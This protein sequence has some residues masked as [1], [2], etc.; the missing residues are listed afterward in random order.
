METKN[1]MQNIYNFVD[2]L[3]FHKYIGITQKQEEKIHRN[4][5]ETRR[6]NTQEL[7]RNKKKKYIGI[8]QK[9]EEKIHRN[10]IEIRRKNTQE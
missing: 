2:L 1:S 7:H 6:K 8:T 3:N 5:I 10:N 4:N 9:Q